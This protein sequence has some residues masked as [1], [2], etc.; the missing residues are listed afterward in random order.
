MLWECLDRLAT[1]GLPD[2]YLGAGCV[3]Q[4]IWN[5]AHDKAPTTDIDDYD[6]VYFDPDLSE[7]AEAAVSDQVAGML[8]DLP[9]RPD[10]KN[11]ARVHLWY[12]NRFGYCIQAYSSCNDSITT[13]PTTATAVGVRLQADGPSVYAPFDLDDLF[14]LVIRPNRVQI[15][16]RIYEAKLARW[17]ERWPLLQVRSWKDGVG[18]PGTR[19]V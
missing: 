11:Q 13:W 2:W 14:A 5:I 19:T 3:A 4:T 17:T 16:P 6:V 7:E 1:L 8:A 10:V 15:T 9:V 12:G 18:Q